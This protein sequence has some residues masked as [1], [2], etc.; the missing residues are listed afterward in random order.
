MAFRFETYS[1]VAVID[2]SLW[3]E[4]AK[5]ASPMMEWEYFHA[6][7]SSKSVSMERGYRPCHLVAYSD[8]E[9]VGIA[10]LYERDRAWVEFGDGGLIELLSEITGFPYQFGIVGSIPFTPVPCYQFLHSATIDPFQACTMLLNYIDFLCHSRQLA[11]AR[12]YFVSEASPPLHAA[13][14][15][16]GYICLRGQYYLWM[17]RGFSTFED[18][19]RTFKS[20]RRTK[21]RREIR[22]IR[23]LGIKVRMIDAVEVPATYY[24]DIYKLYIETWI[25]HMGPEIRP[26]LNA[27]FF[28]ILE[29]SYR[30]RNCFC[31]ASRSDLPVGM[32]LFYHKLNTLFGRYWGCFEEIPFLHFTTC[33][34]HPI[35]YAIER[36]IHTVD[37]GFG[38]E[39]KL[40]RGHEIV[41][42]YHYIKFYG[43]RERRM[44]LTVL[45]QLHRDSESG[46]RRI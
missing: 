26:F 14:S 29:K 17:N 2:R 8:G 18:Y 11:T 4:M 31:V 19:L 10:P 39:H 1:Q 13:L 30:H 25:K 3:N 40:I 45:G 37:P 6:L 43:E 46:Q 34:Y 20:S 36:G 44:A 27:S 21:I 38:G 9:P 28:H 16:A 23:E 33:Y 35:R 41:P 7:E 42:I 32:A 12:I 5:W 24:E 22:T 15:Q